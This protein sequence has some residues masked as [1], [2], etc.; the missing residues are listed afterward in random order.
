MTAFFVVM[1][2]VKET[3][4]DD[5]WFGFRGITWH[6]S[7]GF[8]N[9]CILKSFLSGSV[10]WHAHNWDWIYGLDLCDF[11]KD[12]NPDDFLWVFQGSHDHQGATFM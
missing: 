1:G 11:Q 2:G 10:P 5:S 8:V 6:T 4:T 9:P 3:Q 7:R 12:K